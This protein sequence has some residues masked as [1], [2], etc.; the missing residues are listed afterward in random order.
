MWN[1]CLNL[2]IKLN[3]FPDFAVNICET[4]M[5]NIMSLRG[6]V[7]FICPSSLW[8]VCKL[9]KMGSKTSIGQR[10]LV[11]LYGYRSLKSMRFLTKWKFYLETQNFVVSQQ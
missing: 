7:L 1:P 9:N 11:V 8:Q 10:N 5:M 2:S 6:I 3:L 4:F